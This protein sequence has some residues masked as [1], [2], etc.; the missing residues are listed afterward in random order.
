MKGK[1]KEGTIFCAYS[2]MYDDPEDLKTDYE[3]CTD[4]IAC[5][6]GL[7]KAHI[8][9]RELK[10]ELTK[11]ETLVYHMNSSLRVK[12]AVTRDELNWLHEI[13]IKYHEETNHNYL[14]F[15][16]PQGTVSASLSHV[17]RNKCLKLTRLMHRYEAKGNKVDPLLYDFANLLSDYF[18]LLAIKLNAQENVEEID[19]ISR[20]YKFK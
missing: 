16:L 19:F 18:F 17:L 15:V 7:L 8:T 9:D 10:D 3:F 6:I 5:H 13:S 1:M 20:N 12:T 11:V 4:E 14:R 2:F